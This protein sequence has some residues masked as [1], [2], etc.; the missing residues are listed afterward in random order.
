VATKQVNV[1]VPPA[2]AEL[3]L[4]IAERLRKE[5]KFATRLKAWEREQSA[6]AKPA[7]GWTTGKGQGRRLNQ[8]GEKQLK[9]LIRAGWTDA[10]IARA[11]GVR[12]NTVANRR[13]RIQGE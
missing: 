10:A 8:E 11:L 7:P 5:P 12:P 2:A 13:K 9:R 1:R 3:L 4:T 6:L